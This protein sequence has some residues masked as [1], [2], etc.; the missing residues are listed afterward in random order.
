MD[1]ANRES[2]T[3]RSGK[4]FLRMIMAILFLPAPVKSNERAKK[5]VAK[6]GLQ[7]ESR[8]LTQIRAD[9]SL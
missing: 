2:G 3:G 1:L 5:Q 6:T 4:T 8:T 9:K 7:S